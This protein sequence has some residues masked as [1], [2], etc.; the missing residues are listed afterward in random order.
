GDRILLRENHVRRGADGV[1]RAYAGMC[2]TIT[3]ITARTLHVRLDGQKGAPFPIPREPEM[4]LSHAYAL[5][6]RRVQGITLD[7]VFGC[8]TRRFRP[9]EALVLFS[10]H[11]DRCRMV[12]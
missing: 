10:R 2:G 12:T 8:V 5:E 6:L 9:G 1:R 7:E 3:R 4:R 11:E